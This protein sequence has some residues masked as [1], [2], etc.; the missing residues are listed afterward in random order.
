MGCSEVSP[1]VT[2]DAV[3]PMGCRVALSMNSLLL[4]RMKEKKK[5]PTGQE[6]KNVMGGESCR[7]LGG[8]KRRSIGREGPAER[9][10]M[11][12]W[13]GERRRIIQ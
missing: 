6:Q 13:G 5:K 1:I 9:Q 4:R 10:E 8:E 7:C 12:L 3:A 2:D 11:G